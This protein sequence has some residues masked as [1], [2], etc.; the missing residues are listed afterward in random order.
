MSATARATSQTRAIG[1]F[2]RNYL[3]QRTDWSD[4]R[5]SPLLAKSHANLPPALS[6]RGLSTRCRRG[7]AYAD[8][9]QRRGVRSGVP[10]VRDMVHGFVLFGGVSTRAMPRWPNAARR[11]ARF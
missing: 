8:K 11:C 2:R 4:W 7:R 3:P 6:H 1:Y 5:A 9:L 10:R